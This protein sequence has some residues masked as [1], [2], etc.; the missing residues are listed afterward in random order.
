MWL[1]FQDDIDYGKCLLLGGCDR[2]QAI[3]IIKKNHYSHSVP[4]GKSLYFKFNKCFVVY[5]IPANKN[6]GR[7]LLGYDGLVW[8]LTRL[9]APDFHEKNLMTQAISKSVS[10]VKSIVLSMEAIVSYADPNVGHLGGVYR[11]ASWIY[12]GQSEESRYYIDPKGQTVARR[13]FHSGR[14]LLKKSDIE[15]MGFK[16]MSRPGKHRY[17]RCLTRN[18]LRAVSA[19]FLSNG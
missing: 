14:N 9:W 7:F 10:Q 1:N 17:V 13:K 8:E 3:E 5:S 4:S 18:C 16:E 2:E 12:T 19:R 15:A 6:I 11:A